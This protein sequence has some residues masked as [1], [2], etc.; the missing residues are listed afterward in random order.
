MEN[1]GYRFSLLEKSDGLSGFS[2][3]N[4]VFDDYLKERAGQDMRRRAA[5][6]VLLR[7]RNQADIVGYY[8]I[9]SFGIALT[10][11][12]DAMRKR[13]PQYPVVPAVLI[14]RLTLDHRYE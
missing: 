3:R 1:V 11:L 9:G 2:C 4:N 7:I 13:L 8:T 12:P 5:T 6:V 14:G 10:E